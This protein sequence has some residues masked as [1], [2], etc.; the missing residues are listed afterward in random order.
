MKTIPTNQG[1]PAGNIRVLVAD[2]NAFFR[3]VLGRLIAGC[4]GL[5]LVGSAADGC[6]ALKAVGRCH[7]DLA[8]MDLQMSGLNGLQA[9][10]LIRESFPETRIIIVS[11]EESEAIESTC[12][13]QGVDGFV[14]KRKL[15]RELGQRLAELFPKF[16]GVQ[17][18]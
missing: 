18:N 8:I 10:A 16:Y 5:E 4:Q 9:A 17:F 1:Q 2:D 14:P 6:E 11:A 12:L 7:P 3:G 15:Y 13:A